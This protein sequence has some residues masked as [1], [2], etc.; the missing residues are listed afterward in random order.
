MKGK[1]F[2]FLFRPG[3]RNS[4]KSKRHDDAVNV[5]AVTNLTKEF[6]HHFVFCFMLVLLTDYFFRP[7]IRSDITVASSAEGLLLL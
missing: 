7:S 1:S 4:N 5:A 6:Y 3:K 2:A